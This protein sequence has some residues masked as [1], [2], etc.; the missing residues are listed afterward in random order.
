L[1]EEETRYL[2]VRPSQPSEKYGDTGLNYHWNGSCASSRVPDRLPV[3]DCG[4]G[5]LA[6]AGKWQNPESSSLSRRC[7]MPIPFLQAPL[8]E[9][10]VERM[11][12]NLSIHYK[13]A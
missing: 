11:N 12:G 4:D 1:V 9:E 5:P 2:P 13:W 3:V 7:K 8:R 10:D 6:G